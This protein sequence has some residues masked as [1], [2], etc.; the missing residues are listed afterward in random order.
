MKSVKQP[1]FFWLLAGCASIAIAGAALSGIS[2]CWLQ[3]RLVL[4]LQPGQ[5]G[6]SDLLRYQVGGERENRHA[7]LSGF[8]PLAA[9]LENAFAESAPHDGMS[10]DG[11]GGRTDDRQAGALVLKVGG[12]WDFDLSVLV[13]KGHASSLTSGRYVMAANCNSPSLIA[14]SIA[15]DHLNGFAAFAVI[16]SNSGPFSRLI[17]NSNISM[18]RIVAQQ[19]ALRKTRAA[20]SS[21]STTAENVQPIKGAV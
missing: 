2:L 20:L 12:E 4:D 16:F 15:A 5:S 13:A 1:F 18:V 7:L 6:Q 17:V 10:A 8:E 14:L 21:P 19:H 11:L 9:Q 3:N